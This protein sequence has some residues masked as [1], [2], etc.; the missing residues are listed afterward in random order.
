MQLPPFYDVAD[1]SQE[2][3]LAP[4]RYASYLSMMDDKEEGKYRAAL[5]CTPHFDI[6]FF[7]SHTG[8]MFFF[9]IAVTPAAAVKTAA[10]EIIFPIILFLRYSFLYTKRESARA[11]SPKSQKL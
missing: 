11:D 6:S 5:I 7:T 8:Q 9:F 10:A 4:S 3:H 2:H 1:F